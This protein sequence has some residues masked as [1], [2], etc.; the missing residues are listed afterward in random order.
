MYIICGTEGHC[1]QGMKIQVNVVGYASSAYNFKSA[2]YFSVT[3]ALM[4]LAA[5]WAN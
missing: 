1:A 4:I 2:G 3:F 5:I